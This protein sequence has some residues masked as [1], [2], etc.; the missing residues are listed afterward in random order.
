MQKI[1]YLLIDL[2]ILVEELNKKELFF[3]KIKELF[4]NELK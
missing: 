2:K 3:F 1:T 4:K